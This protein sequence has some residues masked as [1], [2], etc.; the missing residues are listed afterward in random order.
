MT[1]WKKL[2][3][4]FE[5]TRAPNKRSNARVRTAFTSESELRL[6]FI[7]KDQGSTDSLPSGTL[8]ASP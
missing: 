7:A 6:E 4:R 1:V 3:E 5:K 8:E 2:K